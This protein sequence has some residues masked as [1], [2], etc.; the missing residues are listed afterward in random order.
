MIKKELTRN[1]KK[2]NTDNYNYVNIINSSDKKITDKLKISDRLPKLSTREA[3]ILLKD[4]KR[5][6]LNK[7]PTRIINPTKSEIGR[8]SKTALEHVKKQIKGHLGLIQ[9]VG[10]VEAIDWFKSLNNKNGSTFIQFD[11]VD[12]YPSIY[13]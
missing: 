2:V 13:L 3:Y 11:M 9:W 8:I 6:F 5:D 7:L 12:F 4:H 10:T 1:Y